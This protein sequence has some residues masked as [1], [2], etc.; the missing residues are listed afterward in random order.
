VLAAAEHR[1]PDRVPVDLSFAPELWASLREHLGLSDAQLWEWTGQDV[2]GVAPRFRN[3]ASPKR[4]ADP[5]IEV[6]PEG[7]CLDIFRVPFREVRTQFQTYMELAGRPPLAACE[8]AA[9][10]DRFPW[11]TTG[12]WDFSHIA[13]DLRRQPEKATA[14]HSRGFF[15]ISHFMRGMDNFMAD[16]AADPDFASALMDRIAEYLLEKTR[17]MLE[18]G[19]GRYTLFEYNDDVASQQGLFISP[20][21]WRKYNRPRMARFCELIH[22]H[23]AKVRYHSCGSVRAI[24]PDLIEIGVDILNPVQARAAGM[25]PFELKREFGKDLAFHGGIDIQELLPRATPAEVRAHVRRVI[26]EVG[27]DGGYI[28]GGTHTLQADIP[29]ANVVALIETAV[30]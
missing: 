12:L 21:M 20:A 27:R 23:G 8:S 26:E 17:R 11:P 13:E 25:D 19:G 15:E 24:L 22:R 28:L 10:L 1:Q 6:T 2:A 3:A 16:L 4:Y 5:T 30:H 14:E 7:Y 9:E 29:V 18:A